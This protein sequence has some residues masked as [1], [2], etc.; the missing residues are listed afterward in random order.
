MDRLKAM[1]VFVE[2]ADRGSLSAAAMHLGMSRAMVSRYLA[3]LEAWVGVRLLHRTTRRL[4]LTPAGSETLPRCRRM[5]EM[6]GDMREAVAAPDA[7]P[8]GLLR[9]TA[10]MSFG[11]AQLAEAVAEFVRRHPAASIDLLLV[12]RAVNLVEERVDLAV[13]ITN[14]LDPNLI[15][16]RLADCRSVVCAA[17]QYLQQHGAPARAEDLS[18]HNCL[19]HSY[20]GRSLWRFER[21]GEP[22][23][24]PVGGNIT[25][26]ETDVLMRAALA[27]A[28]IVMLP[29]YLAAGQIAAGTLRPLLPD[30]APPV[31]GIHGVYVSRRQMPLILRTMLDFLAERFNPAPWDAALEGR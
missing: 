14:D 9:V 7:E 23:E 4:S 22:V 1:Q 18:L 24:V 30:C 5:L 27:G 19:T 15:G 13:R 25:A 17:P 10:A 20:F 28:G 21:A 16:R 2:V 29:T 6:V 12:D 11:G 3:E 26:N 8:R 31:L